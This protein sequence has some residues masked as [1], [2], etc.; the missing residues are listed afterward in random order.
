MLIENELI[1]YITRYILLGDTVLKQHL[2]SKKMSLQTSFNIKN[3]N[4]L[5]IIH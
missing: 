5:L 2:K 1:L 3:F 4:S